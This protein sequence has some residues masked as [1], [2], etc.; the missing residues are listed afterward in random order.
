[1]DAAA[2]FNATNGLNN[3]A[4]NTQLLINATVINALTS[5]ITTALAAYVTSVTTA[6]T[7]ALMAINVNVTVTVP[8]S[9]SLLPALGTIASLQLTATNVTLGSLLNGTAPITVSTQKTSGLCTIVLVGATVCGLVDA[10]TGL[11]TPLLGA[12]GT[13]L[14]TPIYALLSPA[15]PALVTALAPITAGIVTLLGSTLS[16]LFGAG[17]LLSIVVNAQNAP[18][19]AVAVSSNPL[20]SWAASLP[21]PTT[22]PYG[23]GRYD[24]SALRIVMAGAVGSGISLDLGHSS[25]GSNGPTS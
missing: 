18:D 3:Q 9:S 15:V 19:P 10:L 23:T 12:V 4:P 7:A 14:G 16:G 5:A 1:I 24:V 20:P 13:A 11:V 2:L 8:L 25:V 21:G 17:S 22:A 6:I